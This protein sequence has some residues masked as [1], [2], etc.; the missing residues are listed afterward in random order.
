MLSAW[1][2]QTQS[3]NPSTPST[4]PLHLTGYCWTSP[5]TT[6][7]ERFNMSDVQHALHRRRLPDTRRSITHKGTV[8]GKEL[9]ITVG[10]YDSAGSTPADAITPG[11]VFIKIAKH[12][13]D[14]AGVVDA[15]ATT[16]SMALQYGVPWP[17]M[18]E[19]YRHTRFGT[20]DARFTS[21]V[22]GIAVLIDEAIA[23]QTGIVGDHG[24]DT[25]KRL[26]VQTEA[27]GGAIA[28]M[29]DTVGRIGL[30]EAAE[31]IAAVVDAS[32]QN[33]AQKNAAATD[34]NS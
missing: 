22:D 5:I 21:L 26:A 25:A 7:P 19:K 3:F 28:K 4:N 29:A 16:I 24:E 1:H 15:L 12:G 9:Y 32:A 33:A 31:R 27:S 14:L 13:S 10:F 18:R 2:T 6:P 34:S 20:A 30:T 23:S 8:C 17:V 11:E